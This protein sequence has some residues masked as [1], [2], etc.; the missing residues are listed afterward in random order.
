VNHPADH[1]YEQGILFIAALV[2]FTSC[3]MLAQK[4]LSALVYLLAWQD[5]LLAVA[6]ALAAQTPSW[7]AP[8]V[9][10]SGP[11]AFSKEGKGAALDPDF[12]EAVALIPDGMSRPNST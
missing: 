9:L 10:P 11:I 8:P 4:R 2:V 3:L 7:S 1:S 6:T 12:G 5:L